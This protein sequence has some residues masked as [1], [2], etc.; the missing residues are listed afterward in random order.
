MYSIG[1]LSFLLAT[2]AEQTKV[3]SEQQ[4]ALILAAAILTMLL[5]PFTFKIAPVMYKLCKKVF[6]LESIE[7]ESFEVGG[8]RDHVILIGAGRVGTAIASIFTEFLIPF[9]MIE[10]NLKTFLAAKKKGFPIIFGDAAVHEVFD[11]ADPADAQLAII[12]SPAT[13][14]CYPLIGSIRARYPG[15]VIIASVS[16][17]EQIGQLNECGIDVMINPALEASL[18]MTR[19][20]L[21]HFDLPEERVASMIS[22]YRAKQYA[23]GSIL[24]E[25]EEGEG[26]V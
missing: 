2:I 7:T 26:E 15:M 12:S 5:T 21:D 6:H 17:E 11:S 24:T 14:G 16:T 22:S 1:E 19:L 23:A 20:A 8:N 3:I 9:V 13:T 4:S 25:I 10:Y 18:E